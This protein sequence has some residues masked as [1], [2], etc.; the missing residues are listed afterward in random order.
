[1]FDVF[2]KHTKLLMVLLFVLI[3]PSF[4][5]FG[6]ENYSRMNTAGKAVASINGEKITQAEWDA[7]HQNYASQARA[8]DPNIDLRLLDSPEARYVSLERLVRERLLALAATK[9]HLT[10]GNAQLAAHLASDPNI[11]SLRRPDGSLDTDAY[12]RLLSARGMTPA[13]FEAGVRA[14]LS[15][16]QVL[17]GIAASSFVPSPLAAAATG[18]LFQ[19]REIQ[20]A[21]FRPAEFTAQVTV[22]DADIEAFYKAHEAQ[23]RAPDQADVEYLVLDLDTLKKAVNVSEKELHDYYEQNSRTLA[24]KEERRVS[25]ILIAAAATAPKAERD[26]AKAKA[27]AVL[28]EV[29]K[30]PAS[31]ADVAKRESQDPGSAAN[32]GDL[33]YI[34]R[35]AMVKPFEDAAFALKKDEISKVVETEYGYHILHLA[36]IKTPPVPPFEQVRAKIEEDYRN[37]QA[38]QKFAEVAETFRN[39]VYEQADSLQ[40]AATALHLTIQKA[41]GIGRQP[42]PGAPGPLANAHFLEA[43]FAAGSVEK[44]QNTEAIEV[45][46]NQLAAGRV[47]AYR[48]AHTR[49]LA[50][51]KDG[52]RMAL[53]NERAAALARKA[54]EAKLAAWRA[55][56]AS[57]VVGAPL[58]ISREQPAGQPPQLID[59]VLRADASK[60]PVLVPVDLGGAGYAVA[61]VNKLVEVAVSAEEARAR[62]DALAQVWRGAEAQAYYNTLK[63]RFKVRLLAPAPSATSASTH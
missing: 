17:G 1:M 60:L 13:A 28:A 47:T 4:V 27:E 14:E 11:A 19:Q 12:T 35:G 63:D 23:F 26:K 8:Q 25:H 39:T 46:T 16:Q 43:L 62:T 10:V 61:R 32:G 50:E 9:D 18:A 20:V 38:Q 2:R 54:G 34:S 33:D 49:A 41:S 37:Q 45:G 36:D 22:N 58:T 51:V 21:A 5:L 31:F 48:P 53:V 42:A 59:A 7:A 24:G 44:K 6:I 40:P 57:A 56:P 52:V 29:S 30:T 55:Q 15:A 3:I